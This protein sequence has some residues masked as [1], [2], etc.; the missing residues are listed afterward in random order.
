MRSRP[1]LPSWPKSRSLVNKLLGSK[2]KGRR[3]EAERPGRRAHPESL[4]TPTWPRHCA[5]CQHWPSRGRLRHTGRSCGHKIAAVLRR[6]QTLL[7]GRVK[8]N[9]K[10][11]HLE[12]R[13]TSTLGW[14]NPQG[15]LRR[16]GAGRRLWF[17]LNLPHKE[18]FGKR[19]ELAPSTIALTS[20]RLVGQRKFTGG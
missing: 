10:I 15:A 13:T 6:I 17:C 8:Q 5:S 12:S 7:S 4:S 11:K 14:C 2:G 3:H 16:R 1:F 20:T 18:P 19:S 9:T